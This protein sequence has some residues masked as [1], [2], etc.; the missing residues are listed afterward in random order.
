ME[1][2]LPTIIILLVCGGVAAAIANQKGRSAI[3]WFFAGFLLGLVGIVIVAVLPNLKEE[4]EKHEA[5]YRER[6]RLREQLRQEKMKN[7]AF[8]QH[9]ASRLDTHDDALGIDT[10]GGGAALPHHDRPKSLPQR[11]PA[12]GGPAASARKGEPSDGEWYY[13]A[14]GDTQGPVDFEKLKQLYRNRVITLSSFVWNPGMD[15]WKTLSSVPE[16]N[17]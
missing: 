9:T 12:A 5:H 6:R 4:R 15:D 2:S 17:R 11:T 14:N 16:L 8:R 3:G 13:M 10:R 1:D 7:E